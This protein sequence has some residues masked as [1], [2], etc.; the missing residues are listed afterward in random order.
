MKKYGK[1]SLMKILLLLQPFNM[2]TVERCF[3]TAVNSEWREQAL[4]GR[5][6][7]I[8]ISYDDPLFFENVHNLME[9]PWMKWK[10]RESF[11]FLR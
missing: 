5:Q 4:D 1:S 10:T 9:I 3:D 11:Y 8:H 2:L 6:F 7:G